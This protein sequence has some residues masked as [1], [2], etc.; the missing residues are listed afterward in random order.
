MANINV[1][2]YFRFC[3]YCQRVIKD[4]MYFIL[5]RPMYNSIRNA[6][7]PVRFNKNQSQDDFVKLMARKQV[8]IIRKLAMYA[9]YALEMRQAH[10]SSLHN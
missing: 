7:I 6:N 8:N 9:F 3:I 10:V 1:L 2:R 5:R 4:E